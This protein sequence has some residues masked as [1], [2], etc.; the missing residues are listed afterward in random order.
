V[1]SQLNIRVREVP[2]IYRS[3]LVATTAAITPIAACGQT[4]PTITVIQAIVGLRHTALAF[5]LL[6]A[7][8]GIVSTANAQAT[9]PYLG[10]IIYVTYEFCP[11]GWAETNGQLL[12]ISQNQALFAL[13][14]TM[15][16]GN[17]SAWTSTTSTATTS[18]RRS[19]RA[20]T[21]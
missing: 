17:R 9:D 8:L 19:R 18:C 11:T 21:R 14:G 12:S 3:A 4:K 15:Y 20:T 10:E 6:C 16:G 5:L 13:L 1:R 7:S 2:I